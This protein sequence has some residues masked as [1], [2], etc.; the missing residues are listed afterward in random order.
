[1]NIQRKFLR[2][3]LS[4]RD[5]PCPSCGYN[6]RGL[7]ASQCPECRQPIELE[8]RNQRR[9]RPWVRRLIGLAGLIAAVRS[10]LSIILNL[11]NWSGYAGASPSTEFGFASDMALDGVLLAAVVFIGIKMLIYRRELRGDRWA[12]RLVGLLAAYIAME[13]AVQFVMIVLAL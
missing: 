6:L 9:M 13:F 12:A 7:W 11:R 5:V 3:Y 2:E 4:D 10:A 8:I 1:M